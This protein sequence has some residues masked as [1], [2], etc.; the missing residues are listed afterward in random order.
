VSTTLSHADAGDLDPHEPVLSDCHVADSD[1]VSITEHLIRLIITSSILIETNYAQILCIIMATETPPLPSVSSLPELDA[2]ARAT[3]L[4]LLFEPCTQLHTLSVTP[5]AETAFSSY[6]ELT[7]FVGTQLAGLLN[8][9]LESD[10]KWLDAILGA[11]PR[12]GEKKVDSAMSR[13]EQAAMKA[14]E[15]S[16]K[17]SDQSQAEAEA[18][19]QK[20]AVLNKQYEEAFPGLRYVYVHVPATSSSAPRV[21]MVTPDANRP[22]NIRQRAAKASHY[23][24][25]EAPHRE[26]RRTTGK[27]RCDSGRTHA[28][29]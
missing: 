29:H 5:I 27:G 21:Y 22:Q 28:S 18:I 16:T 13:Q 2:L 25:Y 3:V 23:G 10:H 7:T 15:S 1:T 9:D 19:A 14:A 26:R 11:H 4:D 20:L 12:L 6:A 24:G 17:S 8:S